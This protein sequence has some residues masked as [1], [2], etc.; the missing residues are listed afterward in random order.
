MQGQGMQGG[1][2]GQMPMMGTMI[3]VMPMPMNGG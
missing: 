2:M 1:M 3:V